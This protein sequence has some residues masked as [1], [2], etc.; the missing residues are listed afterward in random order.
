MN[1]IATLFAAAFV[2]LTASAQQTEV[3]YLSGHGPEDA[4]Q[5]DF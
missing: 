4:V 2:M 1:T 3:K 5:W